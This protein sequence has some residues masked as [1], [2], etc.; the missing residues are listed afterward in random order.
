MGRVQAAV[1]LDA[2]AAGD[3]QVA[4]AEV[5]GAVVQYAVKPAARQGDVLG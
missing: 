3:R 2:K 4:G 5:V 1:R